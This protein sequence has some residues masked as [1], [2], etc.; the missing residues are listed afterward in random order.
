MAAEYLF[1]L[2]PK[3]P[4]AAFWKLPVSGV[5]SGE[6]EKGLAA[7]VGSREAY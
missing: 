2:V 1:M 7:S 6:M 5:P 3:N 4:I